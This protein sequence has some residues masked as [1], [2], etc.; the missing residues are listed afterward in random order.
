[1]GEI[2]NNL[3][4]IIKRL[5]QMIPVLFIVTVIV[6]LL[7]RLIPGDPAALMLGEKAS[8][9]AIEA[10]R[11]K[12]GLDKSLFTQFFIFFKDLLHFDLG[13]S[14]R[15]SVPVADLLKERIPVT[16]LLTIVSTF[17]TI[18]ISMPLGYLA[19]IKKDKP[20]DQVI[21]ILALL[22]L[23]I[24]SFWIALVLLLIF[25]V[26][27]Q[28]FPVS[29]WGITWADHL[30][31][32]ILPGI[33]QAI[34]VSAIV[35]RNLRNNVVDIKNSDYV[36]YAKSKGLSNKII[37]ERHI[38]RNALIPTTTLLSLKIAWM[39][40]GSVIIETVFTLPGVGALLVNGI[41]SRDYSIVQ[42][43]VI[44]FVLVVQVINLITDVIYSIL[45][46]RVKLQ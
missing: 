13:D 39:L 37:R 38:I 10:L 34:G 44:I 15:Y 8:N 17:F 23:S 45:D 22:G 16:V 28:L 14:I 2:M 46:P 3:N 27:F 12:M 30:R 11:I 31:S 32:L 21:R 35:V 9:E 36:D 5:L 40:G 4:Y 6:F 42:G 20:T 29:G 24:P 18:I 19:G 41:Y 43:V 7:M 25:G 1:M 33:T 26:K